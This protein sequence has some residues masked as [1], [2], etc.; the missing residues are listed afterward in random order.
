MH[1]GLNESSSV[2]ERNFLKIIFENMFVLYM[3]KRAEWSES[4]FSLVLSNGGASREALQRSINQRER[5]VEVLN[6][7]LEMLTD[8]D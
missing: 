1:E 8:D 4:D 3:S 6:Q 7:F 5:E 2:H